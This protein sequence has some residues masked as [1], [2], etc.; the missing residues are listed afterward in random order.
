MLDKLFLGVGMIRGRRSAKKLRVNDVID[1]WRVEEIDKNER[2]LLRAE[3]IL[4][5]MAW[6]EFRIENGDKANNLIVTAYYEPRGVKG[7]LYWYF[8]LPFHHV[9][10]TNLLKQIDKIADRY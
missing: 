9:I 4:P 10:F 1:V 5:G 6:L 3:M 2:L 8:F 7:Q